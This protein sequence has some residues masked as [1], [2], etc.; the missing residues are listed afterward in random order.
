[1]IWAEDEDVIGE[2]LGVGFGRKLGTS[3]KNRIQMLSR[4]IKSRMMEKKTL[5][6]GSV[7]A[8]IR[9]SLSIRASNCTLR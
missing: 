8:R 1:M 7:K 2:N 3:L 5:A 6:K 9:T 4:W